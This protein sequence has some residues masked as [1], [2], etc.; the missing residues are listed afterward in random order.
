[1][2]TTIPNPGSSVAALAL[3]TGEWVL[4]CNDTEQGRHQLAVLV[5]TDEGRSWRTAR[6]LE[7]ESSGTGRF[8]YPT[9]IQARDGT[10]HVVYSHATERGSTIKW[11]Q[12]TREWLLEG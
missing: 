11:A 6:Y 3:R 12:F 4:V 7:R 8:A 9:L 1:V 5:S 2:K 10:I